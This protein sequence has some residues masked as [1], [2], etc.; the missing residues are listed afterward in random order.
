[1]TVS[2]VNEFKSHGSSTFHRVLIATGRAKAAVTAE[3]D[4]LEIAAMLTAIH[5]TAE[6][7]VA[8]MDHFVHIFNNRITWMQCIKHF[9]IMVCKNFLKD[10]HKTIMQEKAKKRKKR[11]PHPSRMRGRGVE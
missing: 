10:V 1:M 9:F 8:T 5:G 6:G 2:N 11:N 3:R 7:G 4:K